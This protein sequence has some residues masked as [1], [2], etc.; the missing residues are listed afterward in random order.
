MR[1]DEESRR[2]FLDSLAKLDESGQRHLLNIEI[3]AELRCLQQMAN[4]ET[5][6]IIDSMLGCL[7]AKHAELCSRLGFEQALAEEV[8]NPAVSDEEYFKQRCDWHEIRRPNRKN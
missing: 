2:R 3:V 8:F 1:T 5:R 4:G 7:D 6:R